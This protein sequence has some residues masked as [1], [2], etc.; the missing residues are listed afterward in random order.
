MPLGYLQGSKGRR[1]A[2]DNSGG[3]SPLPV[4]AACRRCQFR[5]RVAAASSG[6]VSPLPVPAACRRCQF[7]FYF[8][9][10]VSW[11]PRL[12][13]STGI[14]PLTAIIVTLFPEPFPERIR[15][16]YLHAALRR[17]L[18]SVFPFRENRAELL[19]CL[20]HSA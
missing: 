19:R 10:A 1:V 7:R 6:G 4:P 14:I 16:I 20:R 18:P 15:K 3:V 5:R 8:I 11:S 9:A 17:S 12:R 2:A 13:L